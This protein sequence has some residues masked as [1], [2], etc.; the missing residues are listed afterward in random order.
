[1][2]R[3]RWTRTIVVEGTKEFIAANKVAAY[4]GKHSQGGVEGRL[5]GNGNKLKVIKEDFE[6]WDDKED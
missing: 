4:I 1:M 6:T 5:F 3:E 2:I